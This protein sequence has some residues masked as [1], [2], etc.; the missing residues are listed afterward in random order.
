[1]A[2]SYIDRLQSQAY[3]AGI[4]KNTEKSLNWFK[5]R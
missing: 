4:A 5:N 2:V 3:K 1:M